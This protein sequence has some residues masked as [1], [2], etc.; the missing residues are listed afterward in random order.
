MR[1]L[2]NLLERYKRTNRKSP[3][4]DAKQMIKSDEKD[5]MVNGVK[6]SRNIQES[7]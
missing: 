6:S 5:G 1:T 2:C 7:E 3:V 4:S